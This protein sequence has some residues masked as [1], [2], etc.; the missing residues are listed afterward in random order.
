MIRIFC[1]SRWDLLSEHSLWLSQRFEIEY[2]N[3][4][5][6][7]VWRMRSATWKVSE[8]NSMTRL[9]PDDSAASNLLRVFAQADPD[10]AT[11][12]SAHPDLARTRS[13]SDSEI[14]LSREVIALLQ[15]DPTHAARL[16]RIQKQPMPRAFDA[17]L[18]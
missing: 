1:E 10:Y 7:Q 8:R 14:A 5:R 13:S 9:T 11:F 6:R 17:G 15:A 4:G 18:T 2:R 3:A 16:E 12:V